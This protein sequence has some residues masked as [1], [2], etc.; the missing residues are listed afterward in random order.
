MKTSIIL[1]ALIAFGFHAAAQNQPSSKVTAKT[2]NLV[3][4]P[5]SNGNGQWSTILS[6]KLKTAN[7]KDILIG[8]SAEI[9]LFVK[10]TVNSKNMV[11]DTAM[12][13]AEVEFRVLLDGT[14][15]EPG[16][17]VF[18]RRTQ[19]LSATLDGS[20]ANCLR[21]ST[22]SDGSIS[23]IVDL[24]CVTPENISLLND[25]LQATTF[26]WIGVDVAQGVHIISV[27][28]RISTIG[29]QQLGSYSA[30][31]CVGKAS[32]FAESIRLTKSPDV[33]LDLP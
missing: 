29:N 20:I 24:T 23:T 27:Q 5:K 6:N 17:I 19:E 26:N 33:I 7:Q 2:A 11:Q 4:I 13:Q 22:N 1:A 21:S 14:P 30:M 28:A 9:G 25:S 15:V 32:L 18:G 31:A 12:G 3:L 16:I 10:T 8:V